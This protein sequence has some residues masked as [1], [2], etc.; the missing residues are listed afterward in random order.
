[1]TFLLNNVN[2]REGPRA[3]WNSDAG[4]GVNNE[5]EGSRTREKSP[6]ETL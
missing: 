4:V 1:M 6:C 5:F 2:E 3:L